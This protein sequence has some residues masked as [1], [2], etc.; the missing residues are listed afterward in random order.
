M[1]ETLDMALVERAG[2]GLDSM[3]AVWAPGVHWPPLSTSLLMTSIEACR[4]AA[5]VI[6]KPKTEGPNVMRRRTALER[7]TCSCSQAVSVCSPFMTAGMI[8]LT[9]RH[10]GEMAS[11]EQVNW[12]PFP[13]GTVEAAA[14]VSIP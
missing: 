6:F 7:G 2:K 3:G 14:S 9:P 1:Q 4:F 13:P 12:G 5:S 10:A 11:G 8:G